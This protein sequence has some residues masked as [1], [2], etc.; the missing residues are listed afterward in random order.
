MAKSRMVNTHFWKDPYVRGLKAGDKLLFLYLLTNPSTNIAG[1]YEIALDEVA[2]DTGMPEKHILN[3][4]ARF[5]EAGKIIY[6]DHWI[7]LTN[8]IKHQTKSESV[9]QGI[10]SAVSCCPDWIKDT[11]IGRYPHLATYLNLKSNLKSKPK[12]RWKPEVVEIFEEWKSVL[13]KKSSLDAKRHRILADRLA[14]FSVPELK[15]VPCGALRSP[16]H[17]GDNPKRRKYLDISTLYRDNEQVEKFIELATAPP[18]GT[19]V[20]TINAQ[21]SQREAI[22]LE[23]ERIKQ[24]FTTVQ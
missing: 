8:F 16:W 12:R 4:L 11:I 5:T 23:Q 18:Q 22:R 10:V 6:K 21:P 7:L 20:T 15:L 9:E 2:S 13:N 3:S 24:E 1:A 19:I 17:V 14:D